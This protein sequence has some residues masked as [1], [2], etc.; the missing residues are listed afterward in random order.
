ML[1]MNTYAKKMFPSCLQWAFI[2]YK[3][4]RL[5]NIPSILELYQNL[6]CP[7]HIIFTNELGIAYK[8][9]SYKNLGNEM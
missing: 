1:I 9:P 4:R 5:F 2:I 7:Q 6:A 8:V 3:F